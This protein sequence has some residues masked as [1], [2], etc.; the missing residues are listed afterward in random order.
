MLLIDDKTLIVHMRKCGGTSFCT[1]L[2]DLLPSERVFFLGY[3]PEGETRSARSRRKPG[4][5]WKHSTTAELLTG[6]KRDAGDL[7]IFL[8]A[9]RPWWER[10]AS[11]YFHARRYHQRDSKK[12]VWVKNLSFSDYLR[13]EHMNRDVLADF[14]CDAAGQVLVDHFVGFDAIGEVY[15]NLCDDL[16][17]GKQEIPHLNANKVKDKLTGDGDLREIYSEADWAYAAEI[18]RPETELMARLGLSY[19]QDG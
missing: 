2:I 15:A 3:T 13:S 1:G 5:I 12:H 7:D 17:L 18:Y 16:G 8:L 4:G 11:Y 9:L 6:L 10:V 19:R 14:A